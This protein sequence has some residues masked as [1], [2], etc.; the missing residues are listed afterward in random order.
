MWGSAAHRKFVLIDPF[1]I[2]PDTKN[3]QKS[4]AQKKAIS[5]TE[6]SAPMDTPLEA[7]F[8]PP[9]GPG[10]DHVPGLKIVPKPAQDGREKLRKQPRISPGKVTGPRVVSA[11]RGGS[12]PRKPTDSPHPWPRH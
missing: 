11:Q 12:L 2:W 6:V 3:P 5:D 4:C 10:S 9:A 1:R 8:W 7:I